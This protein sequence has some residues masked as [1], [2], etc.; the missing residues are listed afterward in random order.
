[1]VY[2]HHVSTMISTLQNALSR[3]EADHHA[4]N[5]DEHGLDWL[6][7]TLVDMYR[8]MPNPFSVTGPHGYDPQPTYELCGAC[9]RYRFRMQTP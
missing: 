6:E 4:G 5:F 9:S 8:V 2:R 3:A 1:M 7:S